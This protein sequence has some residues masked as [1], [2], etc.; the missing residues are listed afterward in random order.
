LRQPVVSTEASYSSWVAE[1]YP[2][3]VVLPAAS[4]VLRNIGESE[5]AGRLEGLAAIAMQDVISDNL[6]IEAF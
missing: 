6:Q 3:A 1:E 5:I 4:I 2:D